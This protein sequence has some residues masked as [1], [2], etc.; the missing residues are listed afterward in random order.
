[1]NA[2]KLL[3]HNLN[4]PIMSRID[5]QQLSRKVEVARVRGNSVALLAAIHAEIAPVL[6]AKQIRERMIDRIGSVSGVYPGISLRR[7]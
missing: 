5:R 4:A 7:A 3:K 2:A 6:A 1:M